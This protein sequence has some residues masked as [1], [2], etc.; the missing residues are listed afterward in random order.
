MGFK[1]SLGTSPDYTAELETGMRVDGVRPGGSAER[2]GIQAGD[3]LLTWN[4]QEI[5]GPGGLA[6]FLGQHE[7]DDKVKI[8]LQRGHQEVTVEVTLQSRAAQ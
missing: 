5:D 3:I 1:V 2:G 7:P 8:V 6:K 4:G